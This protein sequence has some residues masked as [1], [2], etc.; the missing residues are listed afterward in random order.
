[1]SNIIIS[2]PIVYLTVYGIGAFF[3]VFHLIKYGI[4]PWPKK[5]ATVFL[6]GSI[7]LGILSFMLFV[8]ID[9]KDI[10]SNK[11]FQNNSFKV[12]VIK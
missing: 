12:N 5:I 6:A 3:I 8:Q 9:W 4:T 1:M 7:V 2:I 10:F 11:M